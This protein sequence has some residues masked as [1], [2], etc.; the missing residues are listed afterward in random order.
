VDAKASS[1]VAAAAGIVRV[2]AGAAPVRASMA[3]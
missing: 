3:S 2:E 1:S